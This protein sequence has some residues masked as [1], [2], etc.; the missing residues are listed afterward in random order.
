[1]VNQPST[2]VFDKYGNRLDPKNL[3]VINMRGAG[4]VRGSQ[5]A[6][7]VRTKFYQPQVWATDSTVLQNGRV[8]DKY[9]IDTNP[10][11]EFSQA[12][13]DDMGAP[14]ANQGT[15]P[16]IDDG[17][18]AIAEIL[19]QGGN[20]Q[21]G[22]AFTGGWGSPRSRMTWETAAPAGPAPQGDPWAGMRAGQQAIDTPTPGMVTG[23]RP[24][25]TG[26]FGLAPTDRPNARLLMDR[27]REAVAASDPNKGQQIMTQNHGM[28]I[29]GQRLNN[30][31]RG[32]TVTGDDWFNSV[33]GL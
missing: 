12:Y 23:A 5:T 7:G 22:S 25:A 15:G 20:R 27:M 11:S 10:P 31:N 24:G 33:R 16:A 9:T 32:M 21:P 4:P 1:M 29:V 8:K 2:P 19:V 17:Q 30:S 18:R 13:V 14:G 6:R 28:Q 26:L 3:P